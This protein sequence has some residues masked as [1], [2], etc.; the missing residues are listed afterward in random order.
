MTYNAKNKR[1]QEILDT[2]RFG[3]LYGPAE[4]AKTDRVFCERQP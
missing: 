1:L 4:F 2:I 3:V